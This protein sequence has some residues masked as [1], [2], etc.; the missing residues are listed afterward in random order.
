MPAGRGAALG[1]GDVPLRAVRPGVVDEDGDGGGLM[2]GEEHPML[3]A[4]LIWTVILTPV[5]T[6]MAWGRR[7]RKRLEAK[8]KAS[9]EAF[10][11]WWATTV[12]CPTCGGC[13]RVANSARPGAPEAQ[14]AM[15]G[16]E[17]R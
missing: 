7:R 17:T 15:A 2:I 16:S 9:S 10:D 12:P 8:W 3:V 13:G 11:A 1:D 5:L 6:V 4:L 14:A